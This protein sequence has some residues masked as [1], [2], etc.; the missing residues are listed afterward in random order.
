[1]N[2][3]MTP[4]TPYP[5]STLSVKVKSGWAQDA[6]DTKRL[7]TRTKALLTAASLF[8][9]SAA[10]AMNALGKAIDLYLT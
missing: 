1:M 6:P 4:T 5:A 7:D 9:K 3:D 10:G 8:L 2:R